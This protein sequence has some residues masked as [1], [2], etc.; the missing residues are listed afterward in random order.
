MNRRA[1]L[2]A[3]VAVG[4]VPG[5]AQAASPLTIAVIS[6]LNGSYGSTEYDQRV[7]DAIRSIRTLT[8]D[9]VICTGDMVA[10]Q[11]T[12]PHLSDQQIA[13]MWQAFHVAV[14][15]PLTDA[16]IPLLVTPG[17]HDASAYPG[18]QAERRAFD[19][20]WTENAPQVEILDGERYPF[21]YAASHKGILLIGLDITV[22][23]RLPVEEMEWLDGLLRDE[24]DRHDVR[25]VFGHLPVWPVTQGREND[26]I[27]DPDFMT[28]LV[29]RRVDAYLSGH[30]HGW[31]PARK[32]GVLLLSQACLGG[33]PRK[34]IGGERAERGFGLLK[35]GTGKGLAFSSRAAPDYTV[36]IGQSRLPAQIGRGSAGLVLFSRDAPDL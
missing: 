30:H 19:R 18:F 22:A 36:P 10:G 32:D 9:L 25:L 17:N 13:A 11:K 23:G 5:V 12:G 21:R 16:G 6:D 28:L 31:Y 4:L 3:T 1:F 20:T 33:G 26:V 15:H 34:Y 2:G 7:H 24:G 27:G 35:L 14:T 8:P 29:N